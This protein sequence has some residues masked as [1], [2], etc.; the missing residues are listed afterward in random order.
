MTIGV[1]VLPPIPKDSTDRNRTSPFAFTG[2][3]FEF[4]SVGSSLSIAGPNT[5]INAMVANTLKA[6]ADELE[7]A[8]DFNSALQALIKREITAHW[9][10][11]FNGNGYDEAWI[12]EAEK[13][14]LLNL[15]TLP[16][17][18]TRYLDAKNVALFTEMGV[19]TKDEM[20]D[21]YEIKL[22]KYS[23]VLNIEVGV[24]LEMI[25]KD[26]LPS[27]F[28]YM[29]VL[30]STAESLKSVVSGAKGSALTALLSR[31][32]TLTIELSLKEEEL[33]RRHE[34]AENAGDCMAV[35][36]AYADSVLPAMAA[37][38]AVADEIEP[39]LGEDYQPYP[40]YEDLLFMK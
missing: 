26:I 16:D 25:N 14:G 40:S 15:R 18:M 5:T 7:K 21:H 4:R 8:Q 9:R 2:N 23:K 11:I 13:R 27:A 30:A 24:M 1:D 19:Y 38:R 10:I 12:K 33:A 34:A 31:L 29:Q 17:A 37:A 28:K 35:A 20:A 22:E 36:R 3:K 39:L 32:D 6:F